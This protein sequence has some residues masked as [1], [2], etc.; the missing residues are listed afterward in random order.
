MQRRAQLPAPDTF[1]RR[2][3]VR[4]A[5]DG[6]L[7][8][9]EPAAERVPDRLQHGH[10]TLQHHQQSVVLSKVGVRAQLCNKALDSDD[11]AQEAVAGHH[12]ACHG[13]AGARGH[14]AQQLQP[15]DL[16]L[17]QQLRKDGRCC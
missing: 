7:G 1:R 4:R 10:F 14:V 15:S 6:L 17:L 16:R 9:L 8:K 5:L 11:G 13:A 2:L 12:L 3:L